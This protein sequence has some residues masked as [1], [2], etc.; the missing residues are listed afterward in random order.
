MELV[1]GFFGWL[2]RFV[3]LFF[4]LNF[5]ANMN[6]AVM[7]PCGIHFSKQLVIYLISLW[8]DDLHHLSEA[9]R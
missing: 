9:C 2:V 4:A 6:I 5:I 8:P 3:W 7:R 1:W